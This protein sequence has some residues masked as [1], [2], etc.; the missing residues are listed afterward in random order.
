MLRQLIDGNLLALQAQRLLQIRL[1]RH[2]VPFYP[3]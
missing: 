2:D 3:P 1:K